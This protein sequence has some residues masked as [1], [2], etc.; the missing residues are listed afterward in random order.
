M[1]EVWDNEPDLAQLQL[2]HALLATDPAKALVELKALADRGSVMSMLYIAHA[3]RNGAG[4]QVDLPLAEEWYRR[5]ASRG[6]LSASYEVGRV[7]LDMQDYPKAVEAFRNGAAKNYPPSLHFL[8]MM[9]LKG[10]GVQ[11][12]VSRARALFEQAVSRGNVFAKRSLGVLLMRGGFGLF[13]VAR[14]V[15]LFASGLKDVVFVVVKDRFSD[16]LR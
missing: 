7:C 11:K 1:A 3:V 5:A 10:Q 4:T 14:G 8:G 6:C 2:A 9:Y 16:R 15:W 13:A 12:D